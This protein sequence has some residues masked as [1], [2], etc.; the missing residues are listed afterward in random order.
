[1]DEKTT[2]VVHTPSIY[3][4]IKMLFLT[5]ILAFQGVI[6]YQLWKLDRWMIVYAL[7]GSDRSELTAEGSS[8]ASD[9]F[10]GMDLS[11]RARV[12]SQKPE[13]PRH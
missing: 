4:T 6:C 5:V 3:E 1:M 8:E 7:I 10:K 13:V 11:I 9:L 12:K 2:V